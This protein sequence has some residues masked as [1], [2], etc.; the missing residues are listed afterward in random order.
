MC[1]VTMHGEIACGDP[2][3]SYHGEIACGDPTQ[4]Y[5]GEIPCGDP[6]HSY[7]G[8]T[9]EVLP[10]IHYFSHQP[11]LP[12][13]NPIGRAINNMRVTAQPPCGHNMEDIVGTGHR[14]GDMHCEVT[15]G[16]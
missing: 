11:L 16:K 9:L 7:H 5:H 13:P 1:T 2:T 6:T 4:S 14:E 10:Y 8:S 3:H 15:M 12:Q